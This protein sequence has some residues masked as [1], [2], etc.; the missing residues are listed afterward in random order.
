MP[1]PNSIARGQSWRAFSVL[2][3]LVATLAVALTGCGKKQTVAA[4]S[5]QAFDTAEPEL[6]ELWTLALEADRTN[7][8][9]RAEVLL[10][11]LTRRNLPADKEAEARKQIAFVHQHMMDEVGKGNAEAK[12]SLDKFREQLPSRVNLSAP[13]Q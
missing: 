2:A 7:D 11:E 3:L 9:Y 13:Q 1:K 8:F 6:K 4:A 10:Y 5:P 12:A